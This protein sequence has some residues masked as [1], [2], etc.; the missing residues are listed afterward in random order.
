MVGDKDV[1]GGLAHLVGG[2]GL[3]GAEGFDTVVQL[4]V[5]FECHNFYCL[6]ARLEGLGFCDTV[7]G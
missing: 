1:V 6:P 7:R 3:A 5:I 4:H 2:D